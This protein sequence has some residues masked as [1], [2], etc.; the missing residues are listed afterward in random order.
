[1]KLGRSPWLPCLIFFWLSLA[2]LPSLALESVTLQ[3]KWTHA[4]QFAGYYA[5]K[6]LG[7]YQEAGLDVHLEE[8]QP[9]TDAVAQVVSGR[10]QYGVG[11]SSLLLARQAGQP[12]VA[13]AV[14]FQHSPLVL[15]ARQT[16]ALQGVHDLVGKRVMLEPHSDELIAYLKQEGI[17]PERLVRLEHS[18]LPDD[19]ISGKV[20]AM[21][22]YATNETYYLDQAKLP[23]QI[24]SPRAA[25]IDFYGDNLFTSEQELVHHPERVAAFRA[26]SLR[27][28]QYAMAHPEQIAQLIYSKYSSRHPLAF[29]TT[30]ARRMAPLMHTDLIEIGYMS[31]GR[32]RHIGHTYADLG[33]LP[34]DFS[35]KGF[36]YDVHGQQDLSWLIT[37]AVVFTGIGLLTL[38]IFLMNRRL[39][40]ALAVSRHA[41][42]GL[43]QSEQK[44]RLLTEN[45]ADVV[46]ALD[47]ETLR[48]TYISP[49]V[50]KL[51]GYTPDE[52]LAQPLADALVPHQQEEIQQLIAQ[53][54]AELASGKLDDDHVFSNE[55]LQ[56]RKDGSAVWTEVL[57]R[58]IFNPI[59]NRV[60]LHGVSRDISERKYAEERLKHM[61]RHDALTG[62]ANRALFSD[63]FNQALAC[64]R[65]DASRLALLFL[66]L[67]RFK[68][69]NDSLGH[70][71]GDLVLRSA[72]E[73][74]QACVRESDT[75]ARI[76]GDEFIVLL[77]D[78]ADHGCALAVAEDIRRALNQVFA[79]DGY[80][81]QISTSIGVAMYPE[82]GLDAEALTRNADD[83]M[84]WAKNVGR[85]GV[86][87]FAC[88]FA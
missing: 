83:A 69:I 68:P 54:V 66:D 77:R 35:L 59:T 38:Y 64:A 40:V 39:S 52:I 25:G 73:R 47:P 58:Y 56:P 60:E 55:I 63:L 42:A 44:Y 81:V 62:L 43:R 16:H 26:A 36:L 18:F 3:L 65:R 46:W 49:S 79:V 27:G 34:Q 2:S 10:A 1:M 14:I 72:A 50:E 17:A 28:W 78:V 7:Y 19:L 88:E 53:R 5:A 45:M 13:L 85:N 61:A 12:V 41:E 71:V 30:E 32:W 87:L 67:D 51:R 84:Y 29:Y 57:T 21:S 75:V 86:R 4:F 70:A 33:L 82:H 31:P 37:G 48:F 11:T 15:A 24:Y 74:I 20:D 76:G 23:Y 80:R 9:G 22:A 8:A 6:E